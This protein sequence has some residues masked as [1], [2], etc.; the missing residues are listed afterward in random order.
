[1]PEQRFLLCLAG[2]TNWVRTCQVSP[3]ARLAATGSDD[4][5]VRV[6]DLETR[7]AVHS[8]EEM[9]GAP[10]VVRFHPDGEC[11]GRMGRQGLCCGI[12]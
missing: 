1:M 4:R 10:S 12:S 6:W 11:V 8:F 7:T 3:D 9:G 2:H 5:T